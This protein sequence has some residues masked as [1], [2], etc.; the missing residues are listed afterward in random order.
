[1]TTDEFTIREFREF[2]DGVAAPGKD[3]TS[4]E[5]NA[6]RIQLGDY[7]FGCAPFTS[8]TCEPRTKVIITCPNGAKLYYKLT[9]SQLK[10]L[11]DIITNGGWDATVQYETPQDWQTF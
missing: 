4:I 9:N 5:A 11:N 2:P 6:R 3:G 8:P 1:M 7:P 10:M